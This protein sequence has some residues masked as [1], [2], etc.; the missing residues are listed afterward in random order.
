M[1]DI[2]L[3]IGNKNYSSWSMRPWVWMRHHNISFT[4]KRIP[5]YTPDTSSQIAAYSVGSTVPILVDGDIRIWDSQ[6]ILEYLAEQYPDASAWPQQVA[7]RAHAR[8]VSAEMHSGFAALRSAMPMDCR[9]KI[10]NYEMPADVE[11]DVSRISTIFND[12][13]QKYASDGEWLFGQ[14]SIADAMFTPV[15][16]RFNTYGIKLDGAAAEYI[17]AVSA[18]AAVVEWVA[19]SHQETEVIEQ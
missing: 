8:S 15:V 7:A 6:S 14:Y 17:Q 4:E 19:A 12:C 3:V 2:I 9:R 1:S 10:E 18:Q 13:R 11:K 16:M 5:L